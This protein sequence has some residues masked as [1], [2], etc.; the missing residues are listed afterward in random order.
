M[1]LEL[2][3]LCKAYG[4]VKAADDLN[5]TFGNGIIGILG[6]NGAGKSTLFNMLT[7]NLYLPLITRL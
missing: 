1:E 6:P 5:A 4:N 3:D 7:T 2:K